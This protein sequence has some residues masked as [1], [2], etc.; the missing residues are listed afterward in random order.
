MSKQK[1]YQNLKRHLD[2]RGASLKRKLVEFD[3][4]KSPL[5]GMHDPAALECLVKQLLDSVRRVVFVQRLAGT[6]PHADCADPAST[7]FDPL[8]AAV[9][10]LRRGD[11]DDAI[12]LVFLAV[13]FGK[14]KK[15]GWMLARLVYGRTGEQGVWDWR[16]VSANPTDFRRWLGEQ[17]GV[18]SK[19]R[20]SNH[21]Q[22]E[23]LSHHSVNGTGSIVEG[24]VRWITASGSFSNLVRAIHQRCGQNPTVVFDALYKEMDAVPRFGR[25]GRFDFLTMIGKLGL[26][27]ISPGSAYI[28]HN[29]TG[30]YR[31]IRLLATGSTLG[32]LSR[33]DADRLYLDLGKDLGLGMQELEDALCNWQ[34]SPRAYVYFRG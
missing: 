30:P 15:D 21:R 19:Y 8:R 17:N 5:P 11:P 33:R 9:L 18:L 25:L 22:Y 12:W 2:P 32:R 28:W 1:P 23:S 27:P 20:F 7:R 31:G 4:Q 6:Q 29:A 10:R 16:S 26:G 24:F 13:H 3:K 14:H 34:K